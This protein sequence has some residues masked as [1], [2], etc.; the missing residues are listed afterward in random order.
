MNPEGIVSQHDIITRYYVEGKPLITDIADDVIEA[1]NI[2]TVKDTEEIMY[3][4]GGIYHPMGDIRIKEFL[5]SDKNFELSIQQLKEIKCRIQAKSYVPREKINSNKDLIHLNNG[6][7]KISTSEFLPFDPLLYATA[8]IPI[9]Y[10]PEAVCPQI[11]KFMTDVLQPSDIN[12]VHELAGYLL[13]RGYPFQLAFMFVGGGSNG[14]S[15]LINL[16]KAFVG[17]KNVSNKSLQDIGNDRFAAA[18]L[19]GKMANMYADLTDRGLKSTGLF[20]SLTGGDTIDAQ[21]KFQHCFYYENHAKLIFS[22]NKLPQ[23]SD[24]TD[25][26]FRRWI[27]IDFNNI[28]LG[29]NA[30]KFL[31]YKLTSPQELSGLLNVAISKLKFLLAN[32]G[33]STSETTDKTKEKYIRMSNPLAA[34]VMDMVIID[35]HGWITKENFYNR[36]VSYCEDNAMKVIDKGS[37]GSALPSV[38]QVTESRRIP[39]GEKTKKTGWAGIA[40][41]DAPKDSDDENEQYDDTDALTQSDKINMIRVEVQKKIDGTTF[42]ELKMSVEGKIG[43][44]SF[45]SIMNKLKTDGRIISDGSILRWNK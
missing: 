1:L 30:D 4:E 32:D 14:K 8:K 24:D 2:I 28:F 21:R 15:T 38:I 19:F 11:D 22:C 13:Y 9:D 33:F 7:Y 42:T 25:A 17:P 41:K 5:L 3:Y 16:F 37:I 35:G 27:I 29:A 23:S 26:F 36:Y 40:W 20:K 10:D 12:I 39:D 6:I 44:D 34:F 31:I 43:S 18:E 45:T